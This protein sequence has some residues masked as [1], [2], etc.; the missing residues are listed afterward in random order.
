MNGSFFPNRHIK[1]EIRIKIRIDR[2]VSRSDDLFKLGL[3]NFLVIPDDLPLLPGLRLI[4][5][6]RSN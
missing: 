1:L 5:A 3:Q 2:L 4:A 6:G